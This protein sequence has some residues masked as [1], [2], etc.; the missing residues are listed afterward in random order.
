[1]T[2]AAIKVTVYFVG[3]LYFYDLENAS[4]RKVI[5]LAT[6]EGATYNGVKLEEHHSVVE[7]QGLTGGAAACREREAEWNGKACIVKNLPAKST[8]ELPE[9]TTKFQVM[10]E[11][12]D[13]V[14]TLKGQCPGT[15]IKPVAMTDYTAAVTPTSGALD[16]CTFNGGLVTYLALANASGD[17]VVNGKSFPLN[18]NARVYI[19]NSSDSHSGPRGSHFF[20]FYKAL[21]V[22][23]SGVCSAVPNVR[24]S[25]P[26]CQRF[27]PTHR[28]SFPAFSG[29]EF[30]GPLEDPKP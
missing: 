13:L 11:R 4:Q 23:S 27:E 18:D 8:I 9:S 1:M 26:R 29:S 14:P 2:P 10:H 21:V 17:L 24:F 12:F 25:G 20:W 28:D 22:P 15:T 7:I 19:G 30:C 3:L 6:P 16:L 5:A